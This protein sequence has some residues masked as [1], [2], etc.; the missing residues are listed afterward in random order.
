MRVSVSFVLALA[1]GGS[2]VL[3][4]DKPAPV[5]FTIERPGGATETIDAPTMAIGLNYFQ[6]QRVPLLQGRVCTDS[7]T[8]NSPLVAIVSESIAARVWPR[9]DPLG[10]RIKFGGPDSKSNWIT[11]IGVAADSKS[12]RYDVKAEPHVYTCR[13]QSGR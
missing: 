5:T 11:V 2:V 4:Q 7:D 3:A 6:E 9:I 10:H 1:A 8:P 13:S 12:R